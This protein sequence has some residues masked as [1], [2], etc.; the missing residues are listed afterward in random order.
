MRRTKIICTLGPATRSPERIAALID[1]GMNIA[2]INFSHGTQDEHD[3]TI[4]HVRACARNM[5]KTIAIMQDLQGPKIRV[6]KL[7]GGALQLLPGAKLIITSDDIIG[8][9]DRIST[10]YENFVSDV[11]PGQVILLDDG[12]MKL[13]V[14]SVAGTEVSTSVVDGGTLLEHKGINLPATN[15][16]V[17][18]LTEKDIEDLTFG[19]AHEVDYIA[20]SFVRTA[21][22]VH[23]LRKMIETRNASIPLIAKIEKPEAITN[24]DEIIHAADGVMVARGDLGVEIPPQNVPAIQKEIIRKCNAAGV[25]VITATQMLESMVHNPRPTRAEASD[26]ANAALDGS[27][28]VMLSEETSIG[29]RPVEAVRIMSEICEQAEQIENRDI[30]AMNLLLPMNNG[31][32]HPLPLERAIARAACILAERLSASAILSLTHSGTTARLISHN[33][34]SARIIAVTTNE[35]VARRTCLYWGVESML[36]D[37][38]RDTDTTLETMRTTALAVGNVQTGDTVILTGG[39]PLTTKAQTNFIKVGKI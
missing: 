28:A 35:V 29:D 37:T 39:H 15:L 4:K 6:A 36:I 21:K 24:I 34:P 5:K 9:K 16:S 20:L 22:N 3:E 19:I 10:T 38:F 1:A 32:S 8:T 25:P 18:S 17:P 2:R 26:V 7:Q 23:D 11:K 31:D 30:T 33:R 12:L 27:D 13:R 14:D